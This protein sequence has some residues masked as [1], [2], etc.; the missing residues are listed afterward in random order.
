M[1]F[2]WNLINQAS[3]TLVDWWSYFMVKFGA[4]TSV[5]LTIILLS[6]SWEFSAARD[7]CP[8]VI[9]CLPSD[10]VGQVAFI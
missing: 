2:F 3:R 1:Y 8:N 9:L 4:L 7:V 10:L 6:A 5:V